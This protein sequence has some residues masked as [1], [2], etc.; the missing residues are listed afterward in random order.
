[1]PEYSVKDIVKIHVVLILAMGSE[2]VVGLEL[3]SEETEEHK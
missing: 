1:M 2:K 3:G